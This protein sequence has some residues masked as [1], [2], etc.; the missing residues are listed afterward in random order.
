MKHRKEHQI[1]KQFRGHE[2]KVGDYEQSVGLRAVT[3]AKISTPFGT[4]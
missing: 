2:L 3:N 1:P 4:V